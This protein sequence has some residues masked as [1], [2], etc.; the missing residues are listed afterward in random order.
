MKN[1]ECT[2]LEKLSTGPLLGF[3]YYAADE[4]NDFIELNIYSQIENS[5]ENLNILLLRFL[6]S[7]NNNYEI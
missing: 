2:I 6:I 3:S 5:R 4:Y 7:L 1:W